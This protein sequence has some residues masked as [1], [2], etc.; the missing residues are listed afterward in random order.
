MYSNSPFKKYFFSTLSLFCV[1]LG[2]FLYFF[3]PQKD[4]TGFWEIL[5]ITAI[6][7]ILNIITLMNVKFK[8]KKRIWALVIYG[9]LFISSLKEFSVL[10]IGIAYLFLSIVLL[11]L[12]DVSPTSSSFKYFNVGMLTTIASFFYFPAG[13]LTFLF[14]L[15]TVL[16]YDEKINISQYLAGVLVTII[17]ILEITYLT[18]GF[19]YLTNWF[20]SL[21]IPKFHFEYQIPILVILIFVLVYG[22]INQYTNSSISDD[23]EIS[24]KHSMMVLYLLC[25]IIIYAFFMGD[26]YELLIFVSLPI[27]IIVSRSL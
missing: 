26:N 5:G 1:F 11:L 4:S 7:L 16:Y 20:T 10:N 2:V 6:S 25:W 27:S 9:V 22:W 13:I 21:S 14:F 18:D 24:S 23:V 17:L 19:S 15:I 12:L 3:Y 8:K